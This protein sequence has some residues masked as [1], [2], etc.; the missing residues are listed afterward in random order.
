MSDLAKR[1]A[2]VEGP[3][4]QWAAGLTLFAGVMLFWAGIVEFFQGLSAVLGDDV[5]VSA[6]SYVFSLDLT[7]W[8][9]IHLLIAVAAMVVGGAV[10]THRTWG[11]VAGLV[12]AVVVAVANFLFIPRSPSW[13][14]AA[15]GF[16]VATIWALA[17]VIS[18]NRRLA[19][20]PDV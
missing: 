8:G 15:I 3:K 11:L 20:L 10:I 6:P 4:A 7:T 19:A 1:Q 2:I 17:E 9:W 18:Q 5:F 12:I 14:L 13:P 16:S